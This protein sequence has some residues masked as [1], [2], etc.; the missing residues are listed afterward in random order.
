MLFRSYPPSHALHQDAV[1]LSFHDI[2]SPNRPPPRTSSRSMPRLGSIQPLGRQ[3]DTQDT[4][5]RVETKPC[6]NDITSQHLHTAW[7]ILGRSLIK[8]LNQFPRGYPQPRRT[9]T[10]SFLQSIKEPPQEYLFLMSPRGNQNSSVTVNVRFQ[11]SMSDFYTI[12]F[13][14]Q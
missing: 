10:V 4:V 2:G 9:N 12:M 6:S 8:L 11:C 14:S 5:F 7:P 1:I 3:T 13:T